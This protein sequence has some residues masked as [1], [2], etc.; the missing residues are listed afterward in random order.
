MILK[1]RA[2]AFLKSFEELGAMEVQMHMADN[3]Y[4]LLSNTIPELWFDQAVELG[5]GAAFTSGE[6]GHAR[7]WRHIVGA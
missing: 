2:S 4:T 1:Q 6:E 3:Y 5:L 7:N